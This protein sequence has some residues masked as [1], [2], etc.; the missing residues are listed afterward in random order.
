MYER[1]KALNRWQADKKRNNNKI[2]EKVVDKAEG[3]IYNIIIKYNR[4]LIKG[5]IL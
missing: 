2:Y 4:G 3:M 1:V 5:E